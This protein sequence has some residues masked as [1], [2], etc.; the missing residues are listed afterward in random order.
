MKHEEST[1]AMIDIL[2]HTAHTYMDNS[3]KRQT[4]IA[5][6]AGTSDNSI[7]Q[8]LAGK[9]IPSLTLYNKILEACGYYAEVTIRKMK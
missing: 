9:R 4:H 7:S 2:F 6:Q 8:I 1:K 5:E 3:D